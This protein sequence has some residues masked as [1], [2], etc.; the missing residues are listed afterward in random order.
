MKII[1]ASLC[2]RFYSSNGWTRE[3]VAELLADRN[4]E[5][6]TP[7]WWDEVREYV[8]GKQVCRP[9]VEGETP[10]YFAVYV[11]VPF[12]KERI[13]KHEYHPLEMGGISDGVFETRNRVIT[14]TQCESQSKSAKSGSRKSKKE[15]NSSSKTSKA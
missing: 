4:P 2:E 12:V 3:S 5:H 1:G 13:E 7:R 11:S 14:E 15:T 10:V 6:V 8:D 9:V